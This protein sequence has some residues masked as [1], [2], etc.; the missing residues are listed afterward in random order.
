MNT[1][2]DAADQIVRMSLNGVEFALRI[3]GSGAK[4]IGSLLIKALKSSSHQKLKTKGSIRLNNLIRSGKKLDVAEVADGNLKEFCTV[5]K[6]YGVL[7]TLLKDR[8]GNSG[9]TEIMYKSEDKEKIN[10]IFKKI[11]M[12]TVDM[13][14]VKEDVQKDL[15]GQ[16]VPDRDEHSER[17]DEDFFSKLFE[18]A[19]PTKEAGQNENPTGTRTEDRDPSAN[20][21]KTEVRMKSR[22]SSEN[23]EEKRRSVRKELKEIRESQIKDR[24]SYRKHSQKSQTKTNSHNNPSKNKTTRRNRNEQLR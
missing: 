8:K 20:F 17:K 13:A 4:E 1:T 3:T 21:S 19:N 12:L 16:P 2:A 23:I 6:K 15:S 24:D 18:K 14:E 22:D 10:R 9:K 11:G 5:A 7:Y